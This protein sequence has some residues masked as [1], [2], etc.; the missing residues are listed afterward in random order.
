MMSEIK[1]PMK[2]SNV[3]MAEP[4]LSNLRKRGLAENQ[5]MS[6]KY[7][8][9]DVVYA[10]AVDRPLWK[11][12]VSKAFTS[13]EVVSFDV[14]QDGEEIGTIERT[15]Y[16]SGYVTEISNKRIAEQRTRGGG[17][18]TADT[19]KAVAMAKK[20]F[21]RKNMTEQVSEAVKKVDTVIQDAQRNKEY[22]LRRHENMLEVAM[23]NYVKGEGRQ[24]F[25]DYVAAHAG[26]FQPTITAMESVASTA[27]DL[28]V[29]REVMQ[30]RN[31]MSAVI[32]VKTDGRYIVRREGT[33]ESMNDSE[34]PQE[35][36]GKLGLLKLVN[37]EH[38][39][40]GA[41]CRVTEDV[42][43][44]LSEPNNVSEGEA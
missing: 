35:Y 7:P 18:K 6:I 24:A 26:S 11:F 29:I 22:E 19:T 30:A 13:G 20:K 2:L 17:Y 21:L 36:R 8:T 16:R 31:D 39:V 28:T 27:E 41:G 44:L 9:K 5:E 1:N 33:Y 38:F 15:W 37:P 43:V 40:G 4:L 25:M 14:Y 32:V 3:V 23:L 10:L 12:V 42:F 34:L